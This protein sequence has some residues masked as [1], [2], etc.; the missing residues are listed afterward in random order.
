MIGVPSDFYLPDLLRA[1]LM[2]RGG[3]GGQPAIPM[4]SEEVG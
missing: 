4:G 2:D 1:P 3:L